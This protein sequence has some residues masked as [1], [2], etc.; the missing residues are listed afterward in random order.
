MTA[1]QHF[2]FSQESEDALRRVRTTA[3]SLGVTFD[4]VVRAGSQGTTI[5]IQ[6]K[7][8][9]LSLR[10]DS[11]TVFVHD[12][13]FGQ[14]GAGVLDVP[15][16]E[17]V[18]L[19]HDLLGKLGIP[20]AEIASSVLKQELTQAAGHDTASG[21][22]HL[23]PVVPGKRLLELS[24][25]IEGLP[26]WSSRV[27]LGLTRERRI[28]F[29]EVHWPK[30]PKTVLEE[31][32]HLAALVKRGFKPPEHDPGVSVEMAAGIIHSP[33][34]GFI[35]DIYPAIRVIHGGPDGHG[36]RRVD[37]LDRHGRPVAV[38]RQFDLPAEPPVK[39]RG[40]GEPTGIELKRSRFRA[41]LLGSPELLADISGNTSYEQLACVGYQPQFRRLE[42]A[43]YIKRHTGYGGGLCTPGTQEYVRFYLSFD[44][45][46]SWQ[47]QGITSFGVWDI[48]FPG[49]RLEYA[50]TL[51]ITPAEYFCFAPNLPLVRAILSWNNPPPANTP[52]FAPH[53]GNVAE[54]RIQIG[55]RKF[56]I[57]ADI[58]EAS[59]VKLSAELAPL[60]DLQQP[61]K[62]VQHAYVASELAALYRGKGVPEHRFLAAQVSQWM[63]KP[64]LTSTFITAGFD[65]SKIV[66]D[67]LATSGNTTYE[68]LTCIGLDTVRNLLVGV[69]HVKLPNG[70]SGGL[71]SAGSQEYVA[72]WIDYGSGYTYAGT[73][74]V[75]V[76][77]IVAIPL[78]GGLFYAVFLPIDLAAHRRPCTAGPVTARVRAILS[79][80]SPP[81][82][83]DPNH[84]PVW[85]NRLET[86]VHI[87]P[88]PVLEADD[89]F[90]SAVGDVAEIDIGSDGLANGSAI[91]TGLVCADSPFGGRITIAGH[92]AVS[93]PGHAV[94]GHAQAAHGSGFEL[95]A[96][97][98][99]PA[100]PGIEHVLFDQRMEPDDH[101]CLA[102][103]VR[104]LRLPGLR[105]EPLDRRQ[106]HGGMVLDD[107]RGR[108]RLR[109]SHRRPHR[110]QSGE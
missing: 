3:E 42:A 45:G 110:R 103:R 86:L 74:S 44:N 54:A 79:W 75:N 46:I 11:R 107:R 27:L 98:F 23:E 77:D 97:E 34:A 58:L 17:Y 67:L 53:W 22:M 60:V 65:W 56:P 76:H 99:R 24:R 59:K 104:I 66:A 8:V 85:G 26:V 49:E 31:A 101:L 41:Y 4:E 78:P 6:S 89:P 61:A 12:R 28:G 69:V 71:C 106:H 52:N 14:P 10:T 81:P 33:A 51:N 47:D 84:P 7:S 70:Y 102:R 105:L 19:A 80:N 100:G 39:E 32:K 94:P 96:A 1:E 25:Q 13:R 21:Q 5:G 63:A 55:A 37:Y 15:E 18:A 43:V 64:E 20:T 2:P 83:A 62:L 35:M 73:T 57:W 108:R 82:P 50:V 48:A 68:E 40:S 36:K 88:G 87:T 92:I 9:M 90:L 109:P 93:G 95:R 91:H 72:F 16:Q 38:P 30:I 29:L